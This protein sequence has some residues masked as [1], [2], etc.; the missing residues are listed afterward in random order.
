MKTSSMRSESTKYMYS[1]HNINLKNSIIVQYC[2]CTNTNNY[3]YDALMV[4]AIHLTVES[5]AL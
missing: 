1:T 5:V 4:I 2:T 3:Y